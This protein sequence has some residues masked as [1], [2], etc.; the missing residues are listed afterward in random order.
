MAPDWIERDKEIRQEVTAARNRLRLAW[1][2]YQVDPASETTWQAA[3]AHFAETLLKLNRKIDRFNLIV[4]I[5][6]S[7]RFRLRLEDELR[8]LQQE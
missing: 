8:R 6:T 1:Q 7:Q 3:I 4:P 5:P 2:H